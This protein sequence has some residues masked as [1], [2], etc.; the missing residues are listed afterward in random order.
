MGSIG[1]ES[2]GTDFVKL[3]DEEGREVADGQVGELYSKGP[4]LFDEYYN[5]PQ[6]KTS[7][8]QDSWFSA[9]DM[10]WR[11]QDGYYEIVDRKDNMIITGGEH[12]YP[13]EIEEAV[14][15]HDA[16]RLRRHRPT[17]LIN[18]AKGFWPW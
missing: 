11:D 16:F 10:A 2:L 3:L 4:M 8:I 5:L 17:G 12:V 1:Y 15:S 14:A 9:G 7:G 18:G 13:S 6:K